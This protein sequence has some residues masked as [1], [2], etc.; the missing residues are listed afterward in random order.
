[1]FSKIIRSF[2]AF[3]VIFSASLVVAA[4]NPKLPA[5]TRFPSEPPAPTTRV[6]DVPF[7]PTPTEVV[8]AMLSVARVTKTDVIY[9]L[10]SGDGRIVIAAAKKYGARGVGIDINADLV[11]Q[12]KA[13]AVAEGVADKVTFIEGD[14]FEQDLSKATVITLYLLPAIN[15]KLRPTLLKLKPG[16]RIVSHAFDMGDWK[17]ERTETVGG[18]LVYFW[19]VPAP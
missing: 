14:L 15:L 12:A 19:R 4:Q 11:A 13:S 6:P 18:R 9:D 5:P 2:A 8:D 10:G 7:V 16:T 1:M 3:A 17:P